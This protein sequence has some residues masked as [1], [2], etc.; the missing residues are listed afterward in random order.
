M[1]K[2]LHTSALAV[3]LAFTISCGGGN[4]SPTGPAAIAQVAG[5][6]S[7][8]TTVT[9]VSGGECF[10]PVFQTL[11]GSRGTGTIQIQQSGSSLTATSTDDASGSSCTY[12]G[13]AGANSVAVNTTSCTASD[14]LGASCPNGAGLR[15]IRLQ[16]GG[17]NATLSGNTLSGTAAE[18]YNVTTTGGT[19]VGTLTINY[20]FNANRR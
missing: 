7:L 15:N 2:A 3:A 5:V 6:W 16:T 13:T 4:G 1:R 19:G 9:G 20:S 14:V 8:S 17:V 18:T 11:V 10:A 12:S